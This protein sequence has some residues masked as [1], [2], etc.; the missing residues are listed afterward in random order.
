[1]SYAASATV[2]V[3]VCVNAQILWHA[4]LSAICFVELRLHNQRTLVLK[5]QATSSHSAVQT[6]PLKTT[7]PLLV[8]LIHLHVKLGYIFSALTSILNNESALGY[9]LSS[10]DPP[11]PVGGQEHFHLR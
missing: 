4:L 1:M 8:W 10:L 2:L 11:A 3:E 7:K 9:W 6:G 5:C